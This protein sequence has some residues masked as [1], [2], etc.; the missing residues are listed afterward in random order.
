MNILSEY[1]SNLDIRGLDEAFLD[2]TN[3]AFQN[4]IADDYEFENLIK[5]IKKKIFDETKLTCSI[6]IS[7]NKML[8][9]ICS[10]IN[11]PDGMKI[12]LTRNIDEIKDFM[13]K[14]TVRKIP[15]V[16]EKM[17]QKLNMLGIKNCED[18]LEKYID[19]FYIFN[20]NTYEFLIMSSLGI[21]ET[22]HKDIK[23]S[24]NKSVSCSETFV[25]TKDIHKIKQVFD[26]VSKR[27]YETMLKQNIVGKN[28]TIEI[29]DKND[30][31]VSKVMSLK[32][33]F[34]TENEINRNGWNL[35]AEL[36]NNSS[37]RLI[38]IKLSGLSKTNPDALMKKKDNQIGVWLDNLKINKKKD[39]I[40]IKS[41][42]E[43]MKEMEIENEK[44]KE[45]N[46]RYNNEYNLNDTD[47][48]NKNEIHE[49]DN[50]SEYDNLIGK[51]KILQSEIRKNKTDDDD[52]LPS[53]ILL[54]VRKKSHKKTYHDNISKSSN[55][56]I[57]L[58]ID[59]M[60][61]SNKKT[62]FRQEKNNENSSN[63]IILSNKKHKK[64]N[65]LISK[66][67]I[68][69]NYFNINEMLKL[70]NSKKE[71]EKV[72]EKINNY[73]EDLEKDKFNISKIN[74][75]NTKLKSEL[76]ILNTNSITNPH[77]IKESKKIEEKKTKKNNKKKEENQVKIDNF[78]KK[79]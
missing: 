59:E 60:S 33:N 44:D 61:K 38:R 39:E 62:N 15:F 48:D 41:K 28:L 72:S 74:N 49:K 76:N 18:I 34:E 6:G 54:S 65:K 68:T 22:Q 10:D 27:M 14:M 70:M 8:A 12:L 9:K 3:F 50:N 26:N 43:G 46:I 17:E 29:K 5:E 42:I 20:Y 55:K 52:K 53:M 47:R 13:K 58:M 40:Y 19:L 11:K 30:K 75:N 35:L 71:E 37:I 25:M 1:D 63:K 57:K 7:T 69:K 66:K 78:V 77:S 45:N 79:Y 51:E 67:N 16:G 2:I 24:I 36:M 64:E 21:S 56:N 31:M 23:E 4:Y 32:K 73:N